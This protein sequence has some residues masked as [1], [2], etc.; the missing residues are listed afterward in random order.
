VN[1]LTSH[2]GFNLWQHSFDRC[3]IDACS[4]PIIASRADHLREV[5]S[6]LFHRPAN[7]IG[8]GRFIEVALV[9]SAGWIVMVMRVFSEAIESKQLYRFTIDIAVDTDRRTTVTSY[10]PVINVEFNPTDLENL[11]LTHN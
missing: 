9:V 11:F 6:E 4:D 3:L 7:R 2:N 1:P 10:G 8:D 5:V